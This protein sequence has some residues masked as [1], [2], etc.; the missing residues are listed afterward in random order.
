MV[1]AKSWV[2]IHLLGQV[3]ARCGTEGNGEG[4]RLNLL[5]ER[6]ALLNLRAEG[7]DELLWVR[8]RWTLQRNGRPA[9][10]PSPPGKK[11]RRKQSLS[12]FIESITNALNV[13]STALSIASCSKST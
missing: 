5:D 8:R 2:C 9:I 12:L 3:N 7:I 6:H 13:Y 10:H 11:H 1:C 4:L